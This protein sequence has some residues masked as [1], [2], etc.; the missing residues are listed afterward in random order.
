M[1]FETDQAAVPQDV[2]SRRSARLLWT[3]IGLAAVMLI[4][5]AASARHPLASHASAAPSRHASEAAFIHPGRR[6]GS[7]HALPTAMSAALPGRP[8][9]FE[10]VDALASRPSGSL[11]LPLE[12]PSPT[13][14]VSRWSP[15]EG[16][17]N[18]RMIASPKLLRR[19]VSKLKSFR[20]LEW[21]TPAWE[22]YMDKEYAKRT[23]V[24]QKW[25]EMSAEEK[26]KADPGRAGY[27]RPK[28]A[29][30][31][32]QAEL[33]K[34][35]H[36]ANVAA[37]TGSNV[38][39]AQATEIEEYT[40]PLL[41][42]TR[43][44]AQRD[45]EKKVGPQRPEDAG[46]LTV[47]LDLDECLVH[48]TLDASQQD[49]RQFEESRK[50]DATAVNE[51]V[52]QLSDGQVVRSNMR[53]GL[54]E[55]L[56]TTSKEYE[57]MVYTAAMELY[58]APLLDHLDPEGNIFRH[59]LYRDSCVQAGGGYTK[60]LALFNRPMNR[61]LLVDNNAMCFLPQLQNAVPIYPF[62]DDR[63]DTS[64]TGIASL[65]DRIK[66]EPD[67]RPSLIKNFELE[68]PGALSKLREDRDRILGWT[69]DR[70][71]PW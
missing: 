65:L 46:K 12:V 66:D 37:I 27:E 71:Q 47:V 20:P 1:R 64:L 11:G 33:R 14:P 52:F 5:V 56:A 32:E 18:T 35:V 19:A 41:I 24:F 23:G 68:N 17:R 70:D 21:N 44:V 48:S 28:T 54:Q 10:R 55:F 43:I 62:Y 58:A 34:R 13:V 16:D 63:S 29:E 4:G 45:P 67:V 51:F 22:K 49:L 42:A 31:I 26:M 25:S 15:R 36:D 40:S 6:S 69:P 53:P 59:R 57:L 61:I 30:E 60:D 50:L 39:T 2:S 38:D 8:A 7:G 3:A 9:S